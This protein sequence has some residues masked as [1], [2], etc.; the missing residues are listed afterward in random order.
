MQVLFFDGDCVLCNKTAQWV[1]KK[2][3][4]KNIKF[5][6][7]QSQFAKNSLVDLPNNIDSIVF[8]DGA[9]IFIKS[10]AAF[11]V[12]KYLKNYK[13]LIFLRAIPLKFRDVIYDYIARNRKKWFG[14]QTNCVLLEKELKERFIS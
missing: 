1:G 5:A 10:E 12:L 11:E 8:M 4:A 14:T 13:W 6:S 7:L 2:N 9:K 3:I